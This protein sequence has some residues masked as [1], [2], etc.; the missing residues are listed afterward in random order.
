MN[1]N[2]HAH[3]KIRN[4][5]QL[6]KHGLPQSN[7]FGEPRSLKVY[8][9]SQASEPSQ[10]S[11]RIMTVPSVGAWY[12]AT[13]QGRHKIEQ[14]LRY[15]S[16]WQFSF[17]DQML[18]VWL[19]ALPLIPL[20]LHPISLSCPEYDF[21]TNVINASKGIVLVEYYRVATLTTR[22]VHRSFGLYLLNN[23]I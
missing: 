5:D 22:R 23:I 20:E 1:V 18:W 12:H 2:A 10:K 11:H 3:T 17:P 14:V 4:R 16:V 6:T 15:V 21:V 8:L 9:K 13:I 7:F 19:R